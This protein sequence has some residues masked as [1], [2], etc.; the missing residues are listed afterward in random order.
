MSKG[1]K[2]I[3]IVIFSMDRVFLVERGKKHEGA[4]KALVGLKASLLLRA[5]ASALGK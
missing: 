5:D 4:I 2:F 3:F 1:S